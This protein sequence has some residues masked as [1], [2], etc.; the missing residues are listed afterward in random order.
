[1]MLYAQAELALSAGRGCCRAAASSRAPAVPREAGH[2]SLERSEGV[3][4]R[5][6]GPRRTPA[7]IRVHAVDLGHPDRRCD[8]DAQGTQACVDDAPRALQ[9]PGRPPSRRTAELDGP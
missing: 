3:R 7:G 8:A 5:A 6:A 4:R 9:R 1:M 2:G